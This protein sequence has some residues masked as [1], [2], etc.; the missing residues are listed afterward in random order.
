MNKTLKYVLIANLLIVVI[1]IWGCG[2]DNVT[3]NS[4]NNGGYQ[5]GDCTSSFVV[6]GGQT[7]TL[8]NVLSLGA[9]S[10]EDSLTAI[11][12][13]GT[14]SN[15]F[16][17]VFP[18]NTTGTFGNMGGALRYDDIQYYSNTITV[19]VT[20]YD[21]PGGKIQGTFEG[22]FINTGGSISITNGKF[23]STRQPDIE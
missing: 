23:C 5:N 9:F 13:S 15:T 8:Q 20:K 17:F 22:N 4:N 14:D 19:N 18:G 12:S 10:I 1:A 16:Q 21:A 2:E 11:N 3:N 6:N 7:V